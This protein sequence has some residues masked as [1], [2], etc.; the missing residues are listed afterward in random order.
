MRSIEYQVSTS[1]TLPLVDRHPDNYPSTLQP[2][3]V[4]SRGDSRIGSRSQNIINQVQGRKFG[5]QPLAVVS[6]EPQLVR[7]QDS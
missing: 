1:T 4:V 5:S 3:L 7:V 6:Y 2:L